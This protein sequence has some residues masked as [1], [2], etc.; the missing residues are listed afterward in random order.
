MVQ[1]IDSF[2]IHQHQ[3]KASSYPSLKTKTNLINMFFF[4]K[5]RWKAKKK[6]RTRRNQILKQIV[7]KTHAKDFPVTSTYK[8]AKIKSSTFS[9]WWD[10]RFI[11]SKLAYFSCAVICE[12]IVSIVCSVAIYMYI[13]TQIFFKQLY[14]SK[15]CFVTSVQFQK[16]SWA[17]SDSQLTSCSV[18]V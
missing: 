7:E 6:D 10:I 15:V 2:T 12:F 9:G 8:S 17:N 18:R 14:V 11:H 5:K 1:R 3:I 13:L 4:D 16:I